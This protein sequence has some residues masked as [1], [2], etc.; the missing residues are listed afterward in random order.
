[1]GYSS[2]ADFATADQM[3]GSASNMKAFLIK[4]IRLHE[5]R[6]VASMTCLSLSRGLA[7][8]RRRFLRTGGSICRRLCDIAKVLEPGGSKPGAELIRGFLGRPQSLAAYKQ[9]MNE[10]FSS[11]AN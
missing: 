11:G 9:W 4:L 5:S 2:F 6:R 1:L 7:E 10:E 3:K 8:G